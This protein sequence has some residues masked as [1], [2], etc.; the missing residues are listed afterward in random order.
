MKRF[1]YLM[2]AVLLIIGFA[3]SSQDYF[4]LPGSFYMKKGDNINLHLLSGNEFVKDGEYKYESGKISKFVL[5]EGKKQT[6]LSKSPK[7]TAA[8][9]LNYK[10]ETPG[11]AMVEL[12]KTE[13]VESERNKFLKYLNSEGLDKIAEEAKSNNQ[14]YFVEKSTRYLKTLI[15]VDKPNDKDFDKPLNEEYEIVIKQN[16]YKADYGDDVTAEVLF[17]G[18]P[19]KEAV[20]MLYVKTIS[21]NVFPQKLSADNSGLIFFKLSREGIYMLSSVHIEASKDKNADFESWG[22]SYTFAFSNSGTMPD[23]YKEFGFGNKH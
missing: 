18:Q 11:L 8:N 2:V 20:V 12:I 14:Q 1:V 15:T 6:D 4:L 5:Y 9:I 7:D 23:T 3:A 13:N 16:P 22:T 19:L 21:G 17:H 10:L